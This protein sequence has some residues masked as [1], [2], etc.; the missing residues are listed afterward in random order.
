MY[1]LKDECLKEGTILFLE[2]LP[3]AVTQLK[4]V[5]GPPQTVFF[6][7]EILPK[8]KDFLLG[9]LTF[10]Q[11]VEWLLSKAVCLGILYFIAC[12]FGPLHALG[13]VSTTDITIAVNV[14]EHLFKRVVLSYL[15]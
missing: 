12:M 7:F 4:C 15:K 10:R 11:I 6:F 3:M 5:K 1:T 9:R 13:C 2:C 14:T 8:I